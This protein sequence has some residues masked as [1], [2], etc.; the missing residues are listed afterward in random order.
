MDKIIIGN[1]LPNIPW[2]DKPKNC[3]D[4]VWRF[5][6]NPI[7]GWNPIPK[8]ARVYNS[9]IVPYNEKFAGVF[10]ADQKNGRAT[11]FAGTSEDGIKINLN[12]E[13][14]NWIDENGSPNPTSY[15]YDP[16]V[17]NIDGTYYITWCDDM[18][19]PSIGLGRTTDFKTFVRMP[20]PLLP[21]NRNGVLFPR[22]INGNY[23][24]LS[25]PSDTGH[26]PFGDIYISESPDLIYWGK[27]KHVMGKG[28]QG[29]WQGTKIGAGPIPIETTEGWLLFYH[30]VS[31]TCNGFVYS[32]GAV[33]LDLEI[34]NKVLYR[35]RDYLLTPEKDYETIGFVQ[36]VVFPCA[37]LYDAQT[38]RIAIYYGAADTY[39]AIAFAQVNELIDYI[40]KNSEVV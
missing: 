25:R 27:H 33:I 36:N 29:W 32:F 17:V 28:G 13:P 14:I 12:P 6:G 15:A 18:K 40:K 24:L 4:L 39:T 19:G 34:P 8:A 22:K 16:R 23:Y 7:L 26:T 2:E 35:T 11:L 5:S 31:N 38:G 21:Y 9:A 37:N 3:T 20:N 10:R 30:G 1:S